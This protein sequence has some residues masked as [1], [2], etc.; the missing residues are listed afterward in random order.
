MT[1]IL[2]LHG[3]NINLLGQREP[4]IY[5]HIT[6][7]DVNVRLVEYAAQAGL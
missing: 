4:N 7:A 1:D 2:L 3:P 5:G 6:L